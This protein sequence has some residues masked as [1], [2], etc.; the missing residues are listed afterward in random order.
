MFAVASQRFIDR[1]GTVGLLDINCDRTSEWGK[2]INYY[3]ENPFM[4][5]DACFMSQE[6]RGN[7]ISIFL[8]L[9]YDFFNWFFAF[10]SFNMVGKIR[11]FPRTGSDLTVSPY[12]ILCMGGI[13]S[14]KVS[15]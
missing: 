12:S 8:C 1:R 14:L 4:D 11:I 3:Y 15:F 9:K 2:K 5:E 6:N 7:S 10:A 13:S